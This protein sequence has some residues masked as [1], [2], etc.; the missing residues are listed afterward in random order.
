MP[1]WH[2]RLFKFQ[3]IRCTK[4]STSPETIKKDGPAWFLC[5]VAVHM[6]LQKLR[7]RK[8]GFWLFGSASRWQRCVSQGF[9]RDRRISRN[10]RTSQKAGNQKADCF[11]LRKRITRLKLSIL[12]S[13]QSTFTLKRVASSGPMAPCR[14]HD[15]YYTRQNWIFEEIHQELSPVTCK[16]IMRTKILDAGT[17]GWSDHSSTEMP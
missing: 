13:G 16:L 11:A 9:T 14:S 15:R 7:G 12:Q 3:W 8:R 6:S 2:K 1:Q 10:S 17:S 5:H 4:C